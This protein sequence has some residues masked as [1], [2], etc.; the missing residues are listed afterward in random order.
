[1]K[2]QKRPYNP[3]AILAEFEKRHADAD[4]ML[5]NS[6][7][8]YWSRERNAFL[9]FVRDCQV[10]VFPLLAQVKAFSEMHNGRLA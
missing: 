10:A 3:L 9:V 5:Y 7:S 4:T 1:M 6:A 2:T 8:F